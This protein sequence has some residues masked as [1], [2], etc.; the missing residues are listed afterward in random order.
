MKKSHNCN[1][2][3][4]Q[5]LSPTMTD[6]QFSTLPKHAG[7]CISGTWQLHTL[8]SHKAGTIADSERLKINSNRDCR[9]SMQNIREV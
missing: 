1:A 8:V 4:S 9:Y 6:S 3:I 5:L 7:L 2:A